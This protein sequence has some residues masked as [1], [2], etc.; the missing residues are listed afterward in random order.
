[1]SSPATN[2]VL[3]RWMSTVLIGLFLILLW[4]PTVDSVF[5]IDWTPP[6]SE[7]RAMAVFPKAPKTWRG[8]EAYVVGIE[9]WFNDHFGCRKCLVMWNNKLRWSL[10]KD[11]NSKNV[12]VGKDGWLFTTDAQMIDHYSGLLQFTPED[13]HN[14][15]ILLET[16][17]NWLAKRG[18]AYVFVVTPDK[19]TIYPE[20]LPDW[21]T[22]VRPHTKLDQFVAYMREHSTV[23]VVD[24]RGVILDEK[25]RNATYLATDTH[26]N[27]LGGFVAY[28]ELVRALA[29]ACPALNLE[30]V[31]LSDFTIT[32]VP[33]AGGDL[34][35]LLG[36]S[37]TESN[38]IHLSPKPGMPKFTTKLA[39]P[40]NPKQPKFSDNPDAK[41]TLIIFQDS[42]A[43]TWVNFLAYNFKQVT[44]L[45]Q[46][47]LDPAWIEREKPDIV[48]SEMNERFLVSV[49]PT[50]L[51]EKDGLH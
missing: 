46:Y 47:E 41:G 16:R 43:L 1:M 22:K 29:K 37:V 15:L 36:L 19:E 51:M 42:F 12:L 45:W 2:S 30:P 32:N 11:R 13:L 49:H 40:E 44:Y 25:R 34:A 23:P 35:K 8:V 31:P 6:R 10:F 9:D 27:Y 3:A 24:L 26:W 39:P 20:K 28:Q 48:V 33:A 38:S 4:L 50:E 17:R 7:N 18:I 5:H 21:V 14:W